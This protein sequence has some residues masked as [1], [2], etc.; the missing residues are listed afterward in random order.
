MQNLDCLFIGSATYDILMLVTAPPQSDM[1]IAATRMAVA[2]GGPA[3]TASVAFHSLGGRAGLISA[4]GNDDTGRSIRAD[5]ENFGFP[6]L[7]L[8]V[9]DGA[10]SSLSTIQVEEGGKRCI[11]HFGG[12]IGHLTFDMLDKK[13]FEQARYVHLAGSLEQLFLP[14]AKYCKENTSALVSVDGGNYSREFTDAILPYT[15]IFIPDDKTA[16]KSIGLEAREACR[17]YYER[18]PGTVCVTRGPDGSI[19]YDGSRFYEEE[20]FPVK[21][22]DTTGAGDNFHGAFLYAHTQGWPLPKVLR[23][24]SIFSSMTCTGL[25]GREATPALDEVLKEM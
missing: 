3:S 13:V 25:G 5:L 23:F 7:D 16:R 10:P 17:Y 4:V 2:G 21:V 12:C 6:L 22:L 14:I 24:S 20:A 9:I 15:D 18:G 11:T 19:A 1:R 8:H